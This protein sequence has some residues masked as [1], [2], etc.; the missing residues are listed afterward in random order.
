M[1][2]ILI[3]AVTVGATIAGLILYTEQKIKRRS[4]QSKKEN[5]LYPAVEKPVAEPLAI[6]SIP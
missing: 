4:M 6:Q 2:S 1:K 5:E 3:A